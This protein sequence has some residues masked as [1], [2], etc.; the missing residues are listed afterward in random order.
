LTLLWSILPILGQTSTPTASPDP[1]TPP[2]TNKTNNNTVWIAIIV[3]VTGGL[4]IVIIV[5]FILVVMYKKGYLTNRK[6][7]NKGPPEA[8]TSSVVMT[9]KGG[10]AKEIR[11]LDPPEGQATSILM[12]QESILARV[13]GTPRA[14][15][16][17]GSF[18]QSIS[19]SD[20]SFSEEETDYYNRSMSEHYRYSRSFQDSETFEN[21]MSFKRKKPNGKE[22]S[23]RE[24]KRSSNKD[25][26]THKKGL[27]VHV[28]NHKKIIFGA[29]LGSGRFGRT[30]KATYKSRIFVVKRSYISGVPWKQSFLDEIKRLVK[31]PPHPNIANIVGVVVPTHKIDPL[32]CFDF[33]EGGSLAT[34][35]YTTREFPIER[36]PPLVRDIAQGM[37][38]L[39]MYGMIH[40]LLAA[41]NVLLDGQGRAV[42]CDFG[43]LEITS[44][45]QQQKK[46]NH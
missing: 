6:R 1:S 28:I 25:K 30:F 5:I 46:A 21:S 15:Q 18:A 41:R 43:L 20:L 31:I 16:P 2:P 12:N 37:K 29:M 27:R 23:K 36:V 35:V 19:A 7:P 40:Q 34:P 4:I 26:P 33:I 11:Y 17:D 24:R 44:K 13:E 22:E 39:H 42:I 14:L 3:G 8:A 38:H 9:T 10:G 45:H 32:L